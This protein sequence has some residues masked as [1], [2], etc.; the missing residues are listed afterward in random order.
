[1][2]VYQIINS[3][4]FPFVFVS[5]AEG[6]ALEESACLG[7]VY[8]GVD[9]FLLSVKRNRTAELVDLSVKNWAIFDYLV[10]VHFLLLLIGVVYSVIYI[11]C[12]SWYLSRVL[13]YQ[14]ENSFKIQHLNFRMNC[15]KM[16]STI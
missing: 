5:L 13:L 2:D 14:F 9:V 10:C 8:S 11:I 7:A 12:I 3:A 15:A 16:T 1:V 6:I 4:G